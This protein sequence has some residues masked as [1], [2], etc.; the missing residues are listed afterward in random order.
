MDTDTSLEACRRANNG[1]KGGYQHTLELWGDAEAQL[2]FEEMS[3]RSAKVEPP[4]AVTGA[5]VDRC[6][7][8]RIAVG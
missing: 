1:S 7:R 8:A 4:R 6:R 5:P 3:G 2:F